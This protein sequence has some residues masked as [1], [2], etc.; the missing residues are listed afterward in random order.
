MARAVRNAEQLA[1]R[2]QELPE[3]EERAALA[4]LQ[5][6]ADAAVSLAVDRTSAVYNLTPDKVRQYVKTRNVSVKSAWVQLQI[7]AIPIEEFAPEIRMK[8][9]TWR[10]K[11]GRSHTQKLPSVYFQRM[12]NGKPRLV[13][14]AF[15]LQQRTSGQLREGG[16]I[17]RRIG[18]ARDRLTNIRY[19]SFPKRFLRD[20]LVP[21]VKERMVEGYGVEFRSAFRKRQRGQRRLAGN[22]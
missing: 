2:L 8:Q 7:R 9:Y 4:G 1:R 5:A 18:A 19:F 20:D 6:A 22:R 16:T 17:R 13:R 21:A 3:S 15:P 10:D 12:R 14:P 11:L